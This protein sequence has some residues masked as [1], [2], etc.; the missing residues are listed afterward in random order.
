MTAPLWLARAHRSLRSARLLLDDGDADRACSS[1][2]Y[3][4]FYAVRAALTHVG[5]GER[6]LGKTHS[7]M[8]AAFHQFLVRTDLLDARHGRALTTE[9]HRRLIADYEATGLAPEAARTAIDNAE[10]FVAAVD[11]FIA[12]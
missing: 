8:I 9:F 2:Y 4:M 7:G 5:E 11:A 12:R 10:D 3:A 6:A 1:A